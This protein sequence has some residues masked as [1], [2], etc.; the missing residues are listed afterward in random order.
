MGGKFPTH[1]EAFS[2]DCEHWTTATFHKITIED[3]WEKKSQLFKMISQNFQKI[4]TDLKKIIEDGT[5][6]VATEIKNCAS[7]TRN[8]LE[9]NWRLFR[10]DMDSCFN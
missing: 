7:K 3:C 5:Q 4:V 9:N 1:L 8:Q 6:K 10:E 2:K